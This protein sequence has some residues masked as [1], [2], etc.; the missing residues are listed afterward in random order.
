MTTI[1]DKNYSLL[2][3]NNV[4]K[5]IEK[6]INNKMPFNG[7][8]T[9]IPDVYEFIT[10]ETMHKKRIKEFDKLLKKLLNLK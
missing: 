8:V 10:D 9:D 7:D 5:D 2:L 3:D 1:K 6:I 4:L